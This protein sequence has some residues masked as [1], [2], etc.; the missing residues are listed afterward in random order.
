MRFLCCLARKRCNT[1]CSSFFTRSIY[2]LHRTGNS[3]LSTPQIN[4]VCFLSLSGDFVVHLEATWQILK[5]GA[6][7]WYMFFWTRQT[8][9]TSVGTRVTYIQW[10]ESVAIWSDAYRNIRI[11]NHPLLL[12]YLRNFSFYF[13]STF[14]MGVKIGNWWLKP[15][16]TV[17][18]RRKA[19]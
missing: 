9:K 10:A 12:F 6:E 4:V 19:H 3:R 5:C 2:F 18:R 11:E 15:N 17:V 16:E 1:V 13:S 8:I 7:M 14:E